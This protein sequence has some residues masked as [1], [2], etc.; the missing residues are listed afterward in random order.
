[1]ASMLLHV[2]G[3]SV[4][5]RAGVRRNVLGWGLVAHFGGHQVEVQGAVEVGQGFG[6]FHEMVAMV[7]GVLFA[8]ARGYQPEDVA[9]Y[10]DDDVL[11]YANWS[12]HPDNYQ[13]GRALALEE[14]LRRLTTALY[15]EA[16]HQLVMTYL[17]E[18]RIHKLRGHS[19][20]VDQERA[21]YLARQCAWRTLD[22]TQE[23]PMSFAQ[24]LACGLEYYARGADTPSTWYAPFAPVAL[25]A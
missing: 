7:E 16:T 8:H 24:W 5:S 9:I 12:L 13:G 1:M 20:L 11:G 4:R 17:R 25:A 14:R 23:S 10:T 6:G 15:S 19:F 22:G 21:D 3:S 18:A 2:D